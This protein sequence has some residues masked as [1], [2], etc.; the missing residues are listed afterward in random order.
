MVEQNKLNNILRQLRCE[1]YHGIYG[2]E[3]EHLAAIGII[4][5]DELNKV[6]KYAAPLSLVVMCCGIIEVVLRLRLLIELER[7]KRDEIV[8]FLSKS[9]VPDSIAHISI[10]ALIDTAER[11]GWFDVPG[12]WEKARGL[13]DAQIAILKYNFD[14]SVKA[15]YFSNKFKNFMKLRQN[16][17]PMIAAPQSFDK[18]NFR[19]TLLD[20]CKLF[21]LLQRLIKPDND[22]QG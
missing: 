5:I 17:Y 14:P 9:D 13:S 6:R 16:I 19:D 4:Y 7:P 10:E 1:R 2:N 15:E 18:E 22:L 21:Q 8:K 3:R 20:G 11:M 12:L